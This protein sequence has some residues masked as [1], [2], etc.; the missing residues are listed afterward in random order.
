MLLPDPRM[1]RNSGCGGSC[2]PNDARALHHIA[3][4]NG[5]DLALLPV[6]IRSEHPLP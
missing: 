1:A 4:T 3:S 2:F 5:Y 6:G